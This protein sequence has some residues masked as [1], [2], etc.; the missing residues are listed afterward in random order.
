MIE[1]ILNGLENA[2]PPVRLDPAFLLQSA[3]P[4]IDFWHLVAEEI[5]RALDID[6]AGIDREWSR[7]NRGP[8]RLTRWMEDFPLKLAE[9]SGSLLV[10]AFDPADGVINLECQ[11]EFFGTLRAW[12]QRAGRGWPRLRLLLSISTT[13]AHLVKGV[14][15]SVFV[16]S[17]PL[18]LGEWEPADCEALCVR[19]G[20]D[21][22]VAAQLESALGRHPYLLATVLHRARL[23][24]ADPIRLLD[25]AADT[26]DWFLKE[27][28]RR[29]QPLPEELRSAALRLAEKG[30]MI[31]DPALAVRLA[32][33]GLARRQPGGR[34]TLRAGILA[35]LAC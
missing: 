8:M 2:L 7:P 14:H 12:S 5:A 20:F 4:E 23:D 29:M 3:G 11:D 22:S 33:I 17:D 25:P 10:L 28:A 35:R 31:L 27:Y 32:D 15:Q 16:L 6:P 34:C 13:P 30:S 21:P 24:G 9:R 18:T 19:F 1:H 26:F